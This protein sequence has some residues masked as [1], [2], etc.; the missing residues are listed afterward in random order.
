MTDKEL[1]KLKRTEL[2]ELM[3]YLKE[4][5]EKVRQENENLKAKL[6]AQSAGQGDVNLKILEEV[7]NASRK[8]DELCRA[9]VLKN[10]QPDNAVKDSEEME[11]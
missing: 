5:L 8:I 9:N 1:R 2:L 10:D 4:E 7:Q 3:Y 11:Q 6:E